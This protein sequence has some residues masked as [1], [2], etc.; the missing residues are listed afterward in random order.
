MVGVDQPGQHDMAGGVE[1]GVDRGSRL[2]AAH[3]QLRDAAILDDD[4]ALGRLGEDRQRVLDPGSHR[5]QALCAN[6]PRVAAD[7]APRI[8]AR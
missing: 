8:A 6:A 3:D 5:Q 7:S 1:D 2:G 4:S